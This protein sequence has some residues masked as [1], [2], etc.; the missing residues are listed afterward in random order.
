MER[1][2]L[3]FL[4]LASNGTPGNFRTENFSASPFEMGSRAS[5]VPEDQRRAI[6][7]HFSYQKKY[8]KTNKKAIKPKPTRKPC[9][10]NLDF[11]QPQQS[12]AMKTTAF[13]S[14]K[15]SRLL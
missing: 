6:I 7:L 8:L 10:I 9:Q 3:F 13:P 14:K 11:P 2:L 12:S 4:T 15:I 1:P 5:T